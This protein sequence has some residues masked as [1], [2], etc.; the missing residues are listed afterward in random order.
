MHILSKTKTVILLDFVR[1]R[2]AAFTKYEH[3]S[4]D[5]TYTSSK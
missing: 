5:L 1:L 3:V 2:A 4:K